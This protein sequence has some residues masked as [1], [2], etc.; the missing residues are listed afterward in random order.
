MVTVTREL[1]LRFGEA[2]RID[3]C[4]AEDRWPGI[5]FS[6]AERRPA[7]LPRRCASTGVAREAIPAGQGDVVAPDVAGLGLMLVDGV[8]GDEVAGDGL[9]LGTAL[10]LVP[11]DRDVAAW[12]CRRVGCGAC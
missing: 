9:T 4:S 1:P 7:E 10:V 11:G 2:R 12:E 3:D 8:A 6:N 5:W